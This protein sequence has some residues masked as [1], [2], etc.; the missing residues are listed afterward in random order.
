MERGE[1]CGCRLDPCAVFGDRGEGLLAE[2][3][4]SSLKW[5]VD[6]RRFPF[7]GEKLGLFR[8]RDTAFP[9]SATS[10][11]TAELPAAATS[12]STCTAWL[13]IATAGRLSIIGYA[14]GVGI[15]SV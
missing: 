9:S 1:V 10:S 13:T 5:E 15:E 3:C 4:S 8:E 7:G 14:T 2:V 11:M 6:F 12:S